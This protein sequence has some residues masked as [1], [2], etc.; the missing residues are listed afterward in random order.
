MIILINS[1]KSHKSTQVSIAPIGDNTEILIEPK[2]HYTFI[3]QND[4]CIAA[5]PTVY[6]FMSIVRSIRK[7]IPNIKMTVR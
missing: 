6:P 5:L 7:A 1:K 4:E 2:S 3:H